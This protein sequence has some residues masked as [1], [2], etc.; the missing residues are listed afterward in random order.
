MTL[1]FLGLIF[2]IQSPGWGIGG[3][4]GLICLGLFFGSHL[5][6]NLADWSEILI[7]FI[8]IALILIDL[9]FVMGFGDPVRSLA[10]LDGPARHSRRNPD[11]NQPVL[12][13]HG[14]L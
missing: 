5:L 14:A 1:G 12:K 4:I 6:V 8:G 2:E 3:T 9:F 7:F 11:L 13:P 10:R